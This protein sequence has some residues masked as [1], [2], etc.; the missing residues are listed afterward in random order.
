VVEWL[1]F[2]FLIVSKVILRSGECF[3]PS[4]KMTDACVV[5][6]LIGTSWMYVHILWIPIPI[7][8]TGMKQKRKL[9]ILVGFEL[10]TGR[11]NHEMTATGSKIVAT[12]KE[13]S[14]PRSRSEAFFLFCWWFPI[15]ASTCRYYLALQKEGLNDASIA[16]FK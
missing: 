3:L 2:G 13:K 6:M 16:L 14:C 12:W 9:A 4:V 8:F 7:H 11:P 10:P 15:C 5:R 1:G